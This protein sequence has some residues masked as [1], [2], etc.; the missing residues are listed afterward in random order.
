[1]ILQCPHLKHKMSTGFF[2]WFVQHPNV[3]YKICMLN[4]KNG[5]N[6]IKIKIRKNKLIVINNKRK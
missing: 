4:E 3:E 2:G 6:K 1:M 5:D